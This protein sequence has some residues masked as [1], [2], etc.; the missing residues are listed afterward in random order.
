MPLE[1]RD[2]QLAYVAGLFDGRGTI[3]LWKPS[4]YKWKLVLVRLVVTKKRYPLLLY[5]HTTFGGCVSNADK[6]NYRKYWCITGDKARAF[7]EAIRPL[8]K[9]P[10]RQHQIDYVLSMPS[11]ANV[12]RPTKAELKAR[13]KFEQ[14]W[15]RLKKG[16]IT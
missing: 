9:L 14:E 7:L 3:T 11:F 15:K 2:K 10:I 13:K 5:L 1:Y 16:K 4:T 6:E 8:T 12:F